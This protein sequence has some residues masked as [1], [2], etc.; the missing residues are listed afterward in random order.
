M[1]FSSYLRATLAIANA[2]FKSILRSPA[3]VMF[4]LLFPLIFILVFGFMT[5]RGLVV[6]IAF[7]KKSDTI[8]PI[9][10][11]LR[12]SPVIKDIR[13]DDESA[14]LKRFEKGEICAIIHIDK[15]EKYP[16]KYKIL[17]KYANVSEREGVVLHSL[18]NDIAFRLNHVN[19]KDNFVSIEEKT[20]TVRAYKTI[21]FILP[22]QLGFSLL[23]SGVFGT[24]FAFLSLRV[25]L[26]IKRFFATPIK[27]SSILLGEGLSRL[28]FALLGAII[29]ISLGYF[30]LGFTLLH[31]WT[32]FFTMLL[33]A[34]MGLIVFMGFGFVV[35]GIAKHEHS[36]P[37]L[38]NIITLPQ[39]LLSG[40]FFSIE[41][42]PEWMQPLCKL[43]PLSF[44]NSALRKVAF[45]GAN[46]ID[47]AS[48]CLALCVWGI[49]V[50]I[51]AVRVFRWE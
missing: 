9:A 21:D 19:Y 10:M 18:I 11:Q 4:S 27:R 5:S 2:S 22:G 15:Y 24:A 12:H 47:V 50:Y 43:L 49:L 23:S 46:L 17:V 31:G 13:E 25:S 38:A 28:V 48:E 7:D 26:V 29:I 1:I 35:S 45:E 37:P 44:L 8:N 16:S 6:K 41:A 36:I 30:F 20:V 51:I 32:T 14:L 3:A 39:F 40:T 34:F 42:F 33:L